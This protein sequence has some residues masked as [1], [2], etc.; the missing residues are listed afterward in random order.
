MKKVILLFLLCCLWGSVEAQ[1]AMYR[2]KQANTIESK[3]YYFT[4]LAKFT[5]AVDSIVRKD[6]VL[7][8]ITIAKLKKL[9][10]AANTSDRIQAL[11]FTDEEINVIGSGLARLYQEDN[12]LGRMLNTEIIPSGCYAQY[13]EKGKALIKRIWEQDARGMNRAIRIYAAAEKPNYPSIDSIGFNVH[14]SYYQDVILP[15]VVQNVAALSAVAPAFYSVPLTAVNVLL[16]L[17]DRCQVLDF[18]PLWQEGNRKAYEQIKNTNWNAYPYTAIL[19]LGAGPE[20]PRVAISA[21]GR[22]R[23]GY[24]VRLWKD[25][26]APFIVLSGGRVHPYHTPYNEAAEMKKYI[27]QVWNVPEEVIIME[28]HARHTTTNIRNTAR[29]LLR[30]GFPMDRKILI[31]SS[32]FHVDYIANPDFAVRCEKEMEV[33]PYRFGQRVS[34]RS[35]EAFLNSS[36]TIINPDEPLDP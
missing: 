14:E 12:A 18:E 27:M 8:N 31:T 17:N 35:I 15:T 36:S 34:P 28:P 26:N 10:R 5:P 24:A 29:I 23:A 19:V 32:Q 30:E 22:L 9:N 7:S 33:V 11:L 4:A 2:V 1:T 21:E 3:N 13:K 25:G 16:D 20:D 6:R